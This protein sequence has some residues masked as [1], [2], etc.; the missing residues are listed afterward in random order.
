MAIIQEDN[1]NHVNP[2]QNPFPYG[3]EIGTVD[4][5]PSYSVLSSNWSS[6][7]LY[8]TVQI[9]DEVN[10][11]YFQV[12]VNLQWP[13]TKTHSI[14]VSTVSNEVK[15]EIFYLD[16]LIIQKEVHVHLPYGSLHWKTFQCSSFWYDVVVPPIPAPND[17]ALT[18][19]NLPYVEAVLRPLA[20][21][22][23][24]SNGRWYIKLEG[25]FRRAVTSR[26]QWSFLRIPGRLEQISPF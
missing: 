15:I 25:P 4:I 14:R 18:W 5:Y 7:W 22:N 13:Q 11:L 6:P 1:R 20:P 23:G 16:T 21:P 24:P 19:N 12:D 9:T 2:T 8:S 3:P 17:P 10:P 26:L